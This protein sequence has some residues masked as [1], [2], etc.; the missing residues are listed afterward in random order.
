[1]RTDRLDELNKQETEKWKRETAEWEKKANRCLYCKS[2][3]ERCSAK[4]NCSACG[5]ILPK[6]ECP[7]APPSKWVWR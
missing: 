7:K 3:F 4:K 2:K 1:M 5:A 6:Y